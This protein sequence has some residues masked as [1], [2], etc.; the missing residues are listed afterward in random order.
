MAGVVAGVISGVVLTAIIIFFLYFFW[1]RRG[2]AIH[3][4]RLA[5]KAEGREGKEKGKPPMPMAQ[6]PYNPQAISP[7]IE[8][9]EVG[10]EGTSNR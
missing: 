8:E 7:F 4:G 10:G 5:G 6:K 2:R 9:E 1:R 3:W